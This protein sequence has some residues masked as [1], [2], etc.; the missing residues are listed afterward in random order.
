MCVHCTGYDDDHD[1]DDGDDFNTNRM[2]ML[3]QFFLTVYRTFTISLS[4]S[5]NEIY[6]SNE[7]R[8]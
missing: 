3:L 7:H 4:Q 1:D 8:A 2:M 5:V 6:V